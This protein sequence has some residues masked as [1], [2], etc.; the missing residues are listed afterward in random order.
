M[1]RLH[2]RTLELLASRPKHLSLR[3][4]AEETGINYNWLRNFSE[5]RRPDPSVN[6]VEKLYV[7]LSGRALDI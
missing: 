6:T 2:A 4:L 7:H 5:K 1:L 3:K